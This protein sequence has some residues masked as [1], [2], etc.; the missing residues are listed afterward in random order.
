MFCYLRINRERYTTYGSHQDSLIA[1]I[2]SEALFCSV[3]VR[4]NSEAREKRGEQSRVFNVHLSDDERAISGAARPAADIIDKLEAR[5][6]RTRGQRHSPRRTG[7]DW[8]VRVGVRSTRVS[9]VAASH[10]RTGI[11]MCCTIMCA[12]RVRAGGPGPRAH[13]DGGRAQAQA[14]RRQRVRRGHSRAALEEVPRAG[15]LHTHMFLY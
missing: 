4:S 12:V 13:A 11:D 8:S 9:N 3:L 2:F 15:P 7:L 10:Q 6:H 14:V 1:S 5:G